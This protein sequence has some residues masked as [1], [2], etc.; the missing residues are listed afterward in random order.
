MFSSWTGRN[1]PKK[2]DGFPRN[3]DNEPSRK[4]L[5][6]LSLST[7]QDKE[8]IDG[9]SSN[10]GK[11]K[12]YKNRSYESKR[13]VS[14]GSDTFV[15][16]N[17]SSDDTESEAD[18]EDDKKNEEDKNKRKVSEDEIKNILKMYLQLTFFIFYSLGS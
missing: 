16:D 17:E 7:H 8:D 18:N 3:D 4:R 2:R 5:K 12:V 14:N 15:E 13:Q 11:K 9:K 1:N 6:V 10:K